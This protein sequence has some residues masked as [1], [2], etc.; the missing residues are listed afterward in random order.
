[1]EDN[2]EKQSGLSTSKYVDNENDNA[3]VA[4]QNDTDTGL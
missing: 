3:T 4:N 1:M 2:Q